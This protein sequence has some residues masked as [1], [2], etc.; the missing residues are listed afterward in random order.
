M[1]WIFE[2]YNL[3]TEDELRILH[4]LLSETELMV[5]VNERT[6]ERFKTT[7]G[8]PQGDSLSP[9][10]F[11]VYLEHLMR[12]HKERVLIRDRSE[13]YVILFADD[14]KLMHHGRLEHGEKHTRPRIR[15]QCTTCEV[16]RVQTSLIASLEEGHMEVNKDKT[17]KGVMRKGI[18]QNSKFV[19]GYIEP[20]KEIEERIAAADRA[21]Y[22]MAKIFQREAGISKLTKM[23]LYNAMVKPVLMHNLWAVPLK[24]GQR[25]RIDRTHRRH[26]RY[27][28]GHYYKQDEPNVSCQQIYTETNSKPISMDLVRLR[29]TFL[30]HILRR[31]DMYLPAYQAMKQYFK[32]TLPNAAKKRKTRRG[33]NTTS[34]MTMIHNDLR[35]VEEIWKEKLNLRGIR[36]KREFNRLT[37]FAQ[38]DGGREWR[39]LNHHITAR[40][41]INWIK[42]DCTRKKQRVPWSATPILGIKDTQQREEQRQ[43]QKQQQQQQQ[44]QQP[45]REMTE[46]RPARGAEENNMPEIVP[47]ILNYHI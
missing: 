26:M 40:Y 20:N 4:Y 18:Y 2:H 8:V 13:D 9:V 37:T 21:F 17:T 46:Q 19:G 33:R 11:I 24:Q 15:C 7:T 35:S 1:I 41:K 43:G 10:L 14:I 3:A 22:G 25:E 16:H 47:T 23:R 12:R 44:Q 31:A 42:R 45:N 5:K 38:N 34:T 36:N 32:L 6:G 27:L 39:Q 30:G 29:W 28:M